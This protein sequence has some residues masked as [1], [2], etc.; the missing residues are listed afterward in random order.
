SRLRGETTIVL[1][2]RH[3]TFGQLKESKLDNYDAAAERKVLEKVK[4]LAEQFQELGPKFKVVVLD[5]QE[6]GYQERLAD[7]TKKAPQLRAA[8][9]RSAENAIFFHGGGK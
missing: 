4:D 6:E 1:H 3:V 9:D 5:V 2:L 7:V 8:I